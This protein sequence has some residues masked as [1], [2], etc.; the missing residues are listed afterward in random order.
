MR[1]R[2]E[3][4]DL[5]LSPLVNAVEANSTGEGG[6][7][8]AF[9][10]G[11]AFWL[12]KVVMGRE[13][14]LRHFVAAE[15]EGR[16][17]DFRKLDDS[18]AALSSAAIRAMLSSKIPRRDDKR[19]GKGYGALRYQLGLK[20]PRKALRELAAEMG[21]ALTT[22]T[23][24]LLMSPQSVA[25]YLPA[26]TALFDLVIFDEASQI[27]PWDAI[28]AIA[29]GRQLIVAG[30]PKQMPPTSFF[31]RNTVTD[32]DGADSA[33]P[34]QE[35]ILEQCL[36]A[37]LPHHRLT[38][39]YRSR[40]E[41]LIAF[42]NHR[43][44]DDELI[45]FPAAVTRD[46]AVS[47]RRIDGVYA[48]GKGR[49][50]AEEAKALVEEVIRRLR[51][52]NFVD[53]Q[54]HR[55]T[56]GVIT[57]NSEQQK[58][59]EDLLDRQR[60][61]HPEIEPFFDEALDEPVIVKNLE[62]IQ[63][64]ERDLI[65]LG[66]G[67]GPSVAGASD[68]SMNFG[69]LNRDGGW[70][71]W[72][73]AITRAR[74]EMML[75]ASFAPGMIDINRTRARAVKDLR[76]Y[77]DFAVRGMRAL[78]QADRG[79]V[80]GYES[81]FEMAVAR[82]LRDR[83]WEV[84]TQIGA[85]RFRIDLG[86]VHPDRPGDYLAGVECDGAAYHS[87]ATARDRDKVRESIL[88][89]LGWDIV[90]VWSTDWWHDRAGA[91]AKL[92]ARLRELLAASPL[93][94]PVVEGTSSVEPDDGVA[95]TVAPSPRYP[96]ATTRSEKIDVVEQTAVF[97]RA[98]DLAPPTVD[99]RFRRADLSRFEAVLRPDRFYEQDYDPVLRDLAGYIVKA[100]APLRD[101]V[102]VERIARAHGFQRSGRL[103]RER[104]LKLRGRPFLRWADPVGGDF[105]WPDAGSRDIWSA[106]R[107][108]ASEDDIRQIEDIASEE[109][110]AGAAVIEAHDVAWELSRRLGI[111]RLSSSAR[112]RIDSAIN[113]PSRQL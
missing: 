33:E 41:S 69:P 2:N 57:L 65:L 24:C 95:P 47:F 26:D 13:P 62:S 23:P 75:F 74:R 22:L 36:S 90:R 12:A 66:V 50:N 4:V 44:Y 99:A 58:L 59:V 83:G 68:M 37:N 31:Q 18:L 77:Q 11:Y 17:A 67:Y 1:V 86:I 100:E 25:Q 98:F 76:D 27:T 73:V 32:D 54:G 111:R 63:G 60:Q 55:L 101:D 8:K 15:H 81:P 40:H 35:S 91:L 102:L 93:R 70:R 42:S 108:P 9:E 105:V 49:T 87:A 10:V 103:I 14:A 39:H 104:I 30:D 34:D 89:G 78:P 80:G 92:D 72:N 5:D 46:S 79:S 28:G 97:A 16:I 94:D 110:R 106:F 82:G 21:D 88:R 71:R 19:L 109:L 6:A 43:Y 7:A 48:K 51:D 112:L 53:E 38:W 29:R 56:L 61:Q 52:P 84:R 113:F 96:P 107:I 64:D 45:T 3:A 20:A 85:S